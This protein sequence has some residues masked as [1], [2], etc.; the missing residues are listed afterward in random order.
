MRSPLFRT[1]QSAFYYWHD[2]DGSGK[3]TYRFDS[4]YVNKL[5]KLLD[6]CEANG[7]QV[8]LGEWGAP[9]SVTGISLANDDPLWTRI[10]VEFLMELFRRRSY[11]CVRYFNLINEPHGSWSSTA[12]C[13]D[14]WRS[15]ILNLHQDLQR[16][17]LHD[18]VAIAAPDANSE[19]LRK[20]LTDSELREVTAI[21]DEHWY[22]TR[23]EI[24]AGA[25]EQRCREQCRCIS[26]CDPG[27]PYILGELGI[28]D[29]KTEDDRQ[30]NVFGFSYG[31]EMADAAVQLMRGGSH[32]FIA[33]YLDDAMHFFGD[34]EIVRSDDEPLPKDAYERRKVW[35]MWN[36][37]GNQ[38]GDPSDAQLRPWFFTW[39]L[40]S[41]YFPAGCEIV[42]VE[43]DQDAPVIIA[44]ARI[45]QEGTNHISLAIVNREDAPRTV[46][47]HI[48]E[49]QVLTTLARFDYFDLDSDDRPDSWPTSID[50]QGCD[51]FPSPSLFL[52]EV[53]FQSGLKIALDGRGVVILTSLETAETMP[54]LYRSP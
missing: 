15:A 13:F 10:V 45:S 35:G 1:M 54:P 52:S 11:Q 42:N 30:P 44:A 51:V 48:P 12:G 8:I 53:D 28:V 18:R 37:L 9:T 6:W 33:W 7:T 41:R 25:V 49:M 39:S 26:Q 14:E 34:G 21:Y 22:V 27:K 40:L 32:G 20:T 24:N 50:N 29:G 47:V 38:M 4:S 17:G 31:V 36:S 16:S 3:P 46:R 43:L 23:D 19:W 5:V 2:I